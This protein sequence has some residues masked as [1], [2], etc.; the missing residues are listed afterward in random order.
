MKTFAFGDG[1][2]ITCPDCAAVSLSMEHL[3][4]NALRTTEA[5]RILP[6]A[7][8]ACALSLML[9]QQQ[10]DAPRELHVNLHVDLSPNEDAVLCC[11]TEDATFWEYPLEYQLC[12]DLNR[13]RH[14]ADCLQTA[15]F[16]IAL[17]G[18]GAA[19]TI[20]HL[21]VYRF[22][23]KPEE[24]VPPDESSISFEK[25]LPETTPSEFPDWPEF[26][27]ELSAEDAY[28]GRSSFD[29]LREYRS[30]SADPGFDLSGNCRSYADSFGESSGFQEACSCAEVP[31][32]EPE[33]APDLAAPPMPAPPPPAPD[34]AES[35]TPTPASPA[36]EAR[37]P[38]ARKSGKGTVVANL[39]AEMDDEVLLNHAATLSVL[40]SREKI[41][42]EQGS[43]SVTGQ[44]AFAAG[45]K[46][47]VELLVQSKFV[48]IGND[49][50]R[51]EIDLPK[52]GNP[53]ELL[54]DL[55]ATEAGESSI[56]IIARQE[57]QPIVRLELRPVV[58]TAKTRPATKTGASQNAETPPPLPK[59]LHQLW[60]REIRTESGLCYDFQINS[61]SLRIQQFSVTPPFKG[62]REA[63][64]RNLYKLIEEKWVA[65][66]DDR[67][68]FIAELRAFGADLFAE[69]FPEQLRAVLWEF[70]DRFD[71]IQVISSEPFIPWELV[72]LCDPATPGMPEKEYFLGQLGMTRW[73]LGAGRNGWPPES[74]AIRKEGARYVI[75]DYHV[76][77]WTL[78]QASLEARFLADR[79]QATPVPPEPGAVRQL[80]EKP[81][82]FDLLHFAGHG[83]A[84]PDSIGH[85]ALLLNGNPETSPYEPK[86]FSETLAARFSRLAT[87]D[88]N[89]PLITVNACQTGRSGYKLTGIGGFA[90]AFLAAGAGA[91]IGALWSVGDAPAR[92]FTETLYAAM[93]EGATLSEAAIQARA[94]S[95]VAGDATWIAYVVYGH[96]NLRLER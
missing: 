87:E 68:N 89:R 22:R 69:L 78:P 23:P 66:A 35:P 88:G 24:A 49:T 31:P 46:L 11:S 55:K 40:I 27:I 5:N 86:R 16:R 48:F 67:S 57:Q 54:F 28:L 6:Y 13:P 21:F 10:S 15:L 19:G 25:Q 32:D 73:L 79:F 7:S 8:F 91:F 72:H 62:D 51:R 30:V 4:E 83:Q 92:T 33:T 9:D 50:G 96:P 47:I 3:P 41:E 65:S 59:P 81:G 61:P 58:I 42:R 12:N 63:Y 56:I 71:G 45:R 1:I 74:I 38:R 20:S 26:D 64:V 93:L 17:P 80:L 82:S 18:K 94:A 60:I 36:P 43:A 52:P 76:S 75:P 39:H 29:S 90:N 53:L 85:A 34:F 37:E 70:R 95:R 14:A 44:G 84:D 77:A 2:A